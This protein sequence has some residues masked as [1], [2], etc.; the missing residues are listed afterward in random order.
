MAASTAIAPSAP[1]AGPGDILLYAELLT[2]LR[3]ITVK[4]SLPTPADQTTKVQ[5]LDLGHKFHIEHY[6][7]EREL[8]LPAQAPI[9]G[10][11]PTSHKGSVDLTWRVPVRPQEAQKRHFVPESQPLPWTSADIRHNTAVACRNCDACIVEQG[12][13]NAWKDLPSE[14]W[15]EM[16]E[17]WHCH[18]P[19]DHT[20][21]DDDALNHR[22]YGAAN[23]INA[24][25]G[26]GFVDMTSL[27]FH[28]SDCQNL[29]VSSVTL[30]FSFFAIF[31]NFVLLLF[32]LHVSDGELEGGQVEAVASQCPGHRYNSPR[33][34]CL[35]LPLRGQ[36]TF[37]VS[38]LRDGL[39]LV[40]LPAQVFPF[41]L[42]V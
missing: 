15:A 38:S 32:L 9:A 10:A 2:N 19:V 7:V 24:Q 23:T 28:E 42:G 11:L 26:V 39:L 8:Q 12:K 17:F 33:L 31:A 25:E 37:A 16:M 1:R 22:G 3:Q 5:I 34:S 14:N 4:A 41:H 21:P 35:L 6:G 30:F 13:I 27:L 29:L 18:K 20:K 40:R 36:S